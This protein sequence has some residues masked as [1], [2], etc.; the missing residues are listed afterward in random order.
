MGS[1]SLGMRTPGTHRHPAAPSARSP[2]PKGRDGSAASGGTHRANGELLLDELLEL[3]LA[4][5]VLVTL[6]AGVLVEDGHEEAD[7]KLSGFVSLFVYLRCV[8]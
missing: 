1:A 5:G 6:L 8:L 2:L 3:P 7:L 4:Q